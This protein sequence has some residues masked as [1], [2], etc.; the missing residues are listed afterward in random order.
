MLHR[1]INC[2]FVVLRQKESDDCR[3]RKPAPDV[4]YRLQL[5]TDLPAVRRQLRHGCSMRHRPSVRPLS[6][7]D[8]CLQ[9]HR[10]LLPAALQLPLAVRTREEVPRASTSTPPSP[11]Q[12]AVASE[13]L[14]KE[15]KNLNFSRPHSSDAGLGGQSPSFSKLGVLSEILLI[16]G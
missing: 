8:T 14:V 16:W 2:G 13:Q 12:E 1:S 5:D 7:L 10:H 15:G 9:H 4:T 3:V 11:I 6:S